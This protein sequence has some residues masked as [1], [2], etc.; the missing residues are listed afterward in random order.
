MNFFNPIRFRLALGFL[1]LS[2][3]VHANDIQYGYYIM[4]TSAMGGS[5]LS[6]E[7]RLTNSGAETWG[8]AHNLVLKDASGTPVA[9]ESL[10]GIE[11][12]SEL[13]VYLSCGLPDVT[14]NFTFQIQA[15]EHEVAYFGPTLSGTV[16]VTQRPQYTGVR[17]STTTFDAFAPA[18][19]STTETWIANYP[20]YRLR[21]KVMAGTAWGWHAANLW[22]TNGQPLD[23]PPPVGNYGNCYQYWVLYSTLYG[24]VLQVGPER[25]DS[26]SVTGSVTLSSNWFHVSSPP[27]IFTNENLAGA[28]Y[29]LFAT[30]RN[31]QGGAWET[32]NG[33]NNNNTFLTNLP[34]AGPYQVDFVWRKYDG[35]LNVIAT[36]PMRTV[37]VYV[38]AGPMS[39]INYADYIGSN[40][41]VDEEDQTTTIVYDVKYYGVNVA[42]AGMLRV[43]ATAR[44]G[45]E[46]YLNAYRANGEHLQSGIPELALALTPGG[47]EVRVT[48]DREVIY[49][50]LG[51]FVPS[52][53]APVITS[54]AIASGGVGANCAEYTATATGSGPI[55]FGAPAR[56]TNGLPPG[57]SSMRRPGSSPA[58][59]PPPART[60]YGSQRRTARSVASGLSSQSPTPYKSHVAAI[61]PDRRCGRNCAV[62]RRSHGKSCA[63]VS[64]DE[65]GAVL[66]EANNRLD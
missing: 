10:N 32:S 2:G 9:M 21:A 39:A 62:A 40:V 3:A 29:R 28:T 37:T 53:T 5:L 64:L 8:A 63:G 38:T 52:A 44:D 16:S 6:I 13:S 24:S 19:I 17:L 46:I 14:A 12:G 26:I 15:L 35:A 27:K 4:P 41:V 57:L 51:D 61:E 23:N 66:P 47:Y 34:P 25:T 7:V 56:A 33:F 20:A 48:A 1:A 30:F 60:R 11:P 58:R 31:S 49:D 22:N 55:T 45:G 42:K 18:A 36:G 43:R 65:N 50:I 59:R 54:P